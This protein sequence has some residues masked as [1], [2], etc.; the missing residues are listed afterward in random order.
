MGSAADAFFNLE[1]PLALAIQARTYWQVAN[2]EAAQAPADKEVVYL[3]LDE[4][5]IAYFYG[6]EQGNLVRTGRTRSRDE[7][8][9]ERRG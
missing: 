8:V 7:V 1:S 4:S 3:N 6:L 2:Y 9:E 5:S